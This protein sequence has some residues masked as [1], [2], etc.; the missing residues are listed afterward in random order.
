MLIWSTFILCVTTYLFLHTWCVIYLWKFIPWILEMHTW[1][2]LPLNHVFS[3][4]LD[5]L[6]YLFCC[7]CAPFLLLSVQCPSCLFP[8]ISEACDTLIISAGFLISL[9]L[10]KT[11]WFFTLDLTGSSYD[12]LFCF[13]LKD[14]SFQHLQHFPLSQWWVNVAYPEELCNSDSCWTLIL[15][16]FQSSLNDEWT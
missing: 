14:S 3:T 4:I 16:P 12:D 8:I 11:F 10:L 13:S 2:A 7:C 1:N 5:D 6:F 9:S 15:S